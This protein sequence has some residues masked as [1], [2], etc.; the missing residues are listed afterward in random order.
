MKKALLG[1]KLGMTQV[2]TDNGTIVPVT[3]VEAGPCVVVRKK[4]ME[5]DGY[6]AVAL[7]FG[8][9]KE[10]SMNKPELGLFKKAGIE[11]KKYIREFKLDN[12]AEMEVGQVINADVFEVGEK[13]DVAG[14]TKG[15]G[16][17]GTIK[18]YG[19]GRLKETH[20]SGPCVRFTG[21]LGA[22]STPSK[23]LKGKRMPGQFGGDNVT[24]QNLEIVKVDTERNVILVKGAIPGSKGGLV[25]I[26]NAVKESK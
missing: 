7:S 12:M 24:I 11:P 16:F 4:T 22:N 5:K 9:V 23:V 19:A 17:S 8:D 20:G 6:E 26:K 21:S 10:K 1:K 15:H 2:F 3:V 25:V 13:V 18:R 14:V